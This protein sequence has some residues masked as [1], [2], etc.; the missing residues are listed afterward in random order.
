MKSLPEVGTSLGGASDFAR[1]RL[2]RRSRAVGDAVERAHVGAGA[3]GLARAG[4]D[5]RADLVVMLGIQQGLGNSDFILAVQALS[6]AGRLSVT[7]AT[8]LAFS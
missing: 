3:V 6:C 7:T 1:N 2:D 4:D 5:D 8:R